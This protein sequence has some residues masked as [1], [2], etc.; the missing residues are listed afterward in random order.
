MEQYSLSGAPGGTRTPGT[1]FRKP[2]LYPPE[3]RAHLTEETVSCRIGSGKPDAITVATDQNLPLG[4]EGGI[5]E[6]ALREWVVSPG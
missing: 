6:T 3:L 1:R 2:L 5:L 4:R